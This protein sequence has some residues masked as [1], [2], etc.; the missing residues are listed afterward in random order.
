MTKNYNENYNYNK[1]YKTKFVPKPTCVSNPKP[2]NPS[3]ITI[4][5][6]K[7][8]FLHEVEEYLRAHI[9]M[10]RGDDFKITKKTDIN[11][12]YFTD[13]LTD[14]IV[15]SYL[16]TSYNDMI[17][18]TKQDPVIIEA[19]DYV[20]DCLEFTS[21]SILCCVRNNIIVYLKN[22]VYCNLRAVMK[23][24]EAEFRR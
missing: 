21:G 13:Y 11:G 15:A 17:E 2:I 5:Q 20:V 9:E 22:Y 24:L 16:P 18:W 6:A 8:E 14:T 12:E 19:T 7:L 1:K 4:H 3:S 10:L 23:R